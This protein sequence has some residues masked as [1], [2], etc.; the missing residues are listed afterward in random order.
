MS[1]NWTPGITHAV[2]I[3]PSPI[4]TVALNV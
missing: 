2:T 1:Q 4:A 3:A